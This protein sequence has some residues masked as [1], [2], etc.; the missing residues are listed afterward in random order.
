M[1]KK[2]RIHSIPRKDWEKVLKADI[3]KNGFAKRLMPDFF[4]DENQED[5]TF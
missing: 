3:K 2:R 1:D 5:W 4:E